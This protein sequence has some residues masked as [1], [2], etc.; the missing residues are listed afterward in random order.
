[1]A[2]TF[3]SHSPTSEIYGYPVEHIKNTYNDRIIRYHETYAP[4]HIFGTG[5]DGNSIYLKPLRTLIDM[6]FSRKVYEEYDPFFFDN[7]K[8]IIITHHHGDH[9]RSPGT[10]LKILDEFPHITVIV[11][12]F[13]WKYVHSTLYKGVKKGNL[14]IY[15]W[16]D[17]FDAYQNRFIMANPMWLKI[18]DTD[19]F[20]L[21]PR[22]VKHG[23][24]VNI[25]LQ[26]YHQPTN[27]RLLYST[28]ID[29]LKGS[30]SFYSSLY[31]QENVQGLNQDET[32]KYNVMFLEAN[33]REELIQAWEDQEILKYKCDLSLSDEEREQKIHNIGVRVSGNRRHISEDEAFNYV[34]RFLEPDGVF[35]P[36]H[37]SSKFGTLFQE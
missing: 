35:I 25:A 32:V 17:K 4:I 33:Y 5:S 23:D 26:I 8:Y 24:I 30:T 36:L 34:N 9:L 19:E 3:I 12:D 7:L 21:N 37:A 14:K 16:A 27:L 29:N 11:S 6:G 22:T 10:L 1:M 18:N 31:E 13:F 20:L 28:D 2:T 15:P